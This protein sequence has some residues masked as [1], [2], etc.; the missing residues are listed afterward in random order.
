MQVKTFEK[1]GTAFGTYWRSTKGRR[2]LM[3]GL[4]KA[5]SSTWKSAEAAG[6]SEQSF[7]QAFSSLAYEYMKEKAPRLLDFIVGF[8]LVDRNEDNTK[9]MGVFGFKVGD[10]W[11]YAPVFFLS[12]DFK[13]HELLYIKKQDAFVPMKENWVNYLISRKPHVLGE[14]SDKN[15]FEL[16][17]VLPDISRFSHPPTS[18]KYGSAESTLRPHIDDWAKPFLPFVGAVA[19]QSANSLFKEKT[20]ADKLA[21][22]KIVA[23]P[24]K[25]AFAE[26]APKFDMRVVL[27]NNLP[28]MKLAYEKFYSRYPWIKRGFDRF[29]GEDFFHKMALDLKQSQ[30]SLVNRV[31]FKQAAEGAMTPP[32][33]RPSD[34]T[35]SCQTCQ[36]FDGQGLCQM[37]G[38]QVEPTAVCDSYEASPNAG[39]TPQ[40]M[41]QS[42]GSV[43][44][45]TDRLRKKGSAFLFDAPEAKPH[46]IKS[47]ELQIIALDVD[48]DNESEEGIK[49][50]LPELT[51]EEREKLL[52]DTVLIKDKRDPHA[53]SMAY[54]TQVRVELTNPS[55]TGL[56]QVLEKPGTFEE[57]LVIAHPLSGGGRHNFATIVRKGDSRSWLNSHASNI[58][59][60]KQESA[61]DYRKWFDGLGSTKDLTKGGVYIAIGENG[62]ATC[63][64][65][66]REDYGNGSY[67]VNWNDTCEYRKDRP[68]FLASIDDHK[69]YS[70]DTGYD[71][72]NAKLL[73]NRAK[74]CKLR[75][76]QGEMTVPEDFKIIKVEDPPKPP[77]KKDRFS[78]M[79][80][81]PFG[82]SYESEKRPIE[83]GNL[84]HIQTMLHK[85]A[86]VLKVHDTGSNEVWI[87]SRGTSERM[88]KKAALI[89]LVRDHGLGEDQ[90]QQII[91][92]AAA[93]AIHNQDAVYFIKYAQGFG[94]GVAGNLQPGPTAPQFPLPPMGMETA[95]PNSY[96]AIYP[97]EQMLP[98]P[99][100]QAN[101]SDAQIYDPFYQ[102]DK[103]TMQVAQQAA[104]SGQKEVFDTAM[105]SGMLKAVR[106]DSLVDRHLGDLM[107]ALD[108][109]GRILF[110]F[111][112]HQEEFEDRYGKQD[113]PELEDSLRNAFETLGDVSLFLK[114]KQ[115]GGGSI[116]GM[117]GE[118]SGAN[119]AEPDIQ[120]AART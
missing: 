73:I 57:M 68:R 17:G 7:E 107:K 119:N 59:A 16:G 9:A 71:S 102:P 100:M 11:L 24:F 109:L 99:G 110:M 79:S 84:E 86:S 65:R 30:D 56:Y 46:P 51:E 103:N 35:T 90:A 87:K 117:A 82:N 48:S 75:V 6:D 60:K 37:Y 19:T 91:K 93:K 18:T 22:D 118:S 27:K 105:I 66:V 85:Q 64:F 10:Q 4:R 8:Q 29:Y 114:E 63:P 36:H 111:Y 69:D 47:G 15:T 58:F 76:T 52:K 80:E 20:A 44:V 96:P 43:K 62:D 116:D 89:S 55:E 112:W 26:T 5:A 42:P 92:E 13:G 70:F 120:E 54:N 2:E 40:P 39:N 113:L 41:V 33:Y 23:D 3:D 45:G 81:A 38:A 78:I 115:V 25:A 83:P 88:S 12:G 104:Q 101:L 53:K 21:F 95:G 74:G 61:A 72:W 106:Q 32:N 50:N 77:K 34:G 108:K 98:V 49:K 97:D 31:K 67:R 1:R 14:P 94:G 28:L